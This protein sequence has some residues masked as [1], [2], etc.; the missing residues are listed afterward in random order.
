MFM[1]R[2]RLRIRNVYN[3]LFVFQQLSTPI[4][5]ETTEIHELKILGVVRA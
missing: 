4:L 5:W 3:I 1:R 2:G